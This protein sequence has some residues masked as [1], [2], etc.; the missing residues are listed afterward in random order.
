MLEKFIEM[1]CQSFGLD[2]ER[3]YTNDRIIKLSDQSS[4]LA[5]EISKLDANL[6]NEID[7][8]IG[9]IVGAYGDV[10]FQEGFKQ[11]L[12]LAHEINQL[13]IKTVK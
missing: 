2:R 4:T 11:G 13:L 1:Q 7:I 8:L 6:G 9:S 12:V 3:V 10:Y 5:K